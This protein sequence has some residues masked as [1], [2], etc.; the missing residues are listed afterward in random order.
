MRNATRRKRR[1]T[2]GHMSRAE[3]AAAT[4]AGL[5]LAIAF[6]GAMALVGAQVSRDYTTRITYD[7]FMRAL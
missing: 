4:F 1:T 3:L 2:Y 5:A 7:A 6:I